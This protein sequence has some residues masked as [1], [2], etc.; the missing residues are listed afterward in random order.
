[1]LEDGLRVRAELAAGGGVD[2]EDPSVDDED[3]ALGV[4][5]DSHGDSFTVSANVHDD[6]CSVNRFDLT[7]RLLVLTLASVASTARSHA[8][9]LVL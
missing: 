7:N 1:V 8:R 6:F 3:E 5:G 4:L 2:V 9:R